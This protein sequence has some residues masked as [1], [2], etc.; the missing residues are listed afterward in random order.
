[1]SADIADHRTFDFYIYVMPGFF[2]VPVMPGVVKPARIYIKPADNAVRI[3][4]N[5]ELLMK[6]LGK[7]WFGRR[8]PD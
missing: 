2:C 3:V 8:W 6:C 4:R 7:E 5:Q 1:M